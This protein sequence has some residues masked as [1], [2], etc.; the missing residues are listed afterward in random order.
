MIIGN[1][2]V[3]K[4]IKALKAFDITFKTIHPKH[5]YFV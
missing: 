1:S 5:K 2:F 4:K 3:F